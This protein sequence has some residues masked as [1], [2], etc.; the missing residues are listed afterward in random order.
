MKASSGPDRGAEDGAASWPVRVL[1]LA[2]PLVVF[3]L[4][5]F[6]S[7]SPRSPTIPATHGQ[8]VH[9]LPAQA[10][11]SGESS[12]LDVDV[13]E[14][15]A[16]RLAARLEREP[17]DA[18]GWSTLARTWYVL[19]RFPKA[20]AAYEKRIA[21]G[22]PPDA[23]LLADYADALA[24]AQGRRLGGTPMRLVRQALQ[25]N[26]SQWKALSMAA[27]DA[28][29]RSDYPA[30]T[31]LW[32]RALAALP[33]GSEMAGSIRASLAEAHRVNGAR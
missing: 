26:P 4:F 10:S 20:V 22:A 29:D 11:A 7:L 16:M 27:T 5:W 13:M 24:M 14:Q 18:N 9:A 19:G 12:Q 30:A 15:A 31:E 21:L 28:F 3:A 8:A 33:P 17:D 25:L 23:D 1:I 32:Q 2:I 6:F